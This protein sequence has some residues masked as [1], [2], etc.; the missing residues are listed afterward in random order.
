MLIIILLTIPLIG[1]IIVS[2][3]MLYNDEINHTDYLKKHESLSDASS[4]FKN[5]TSNGVN[6]NIS[7]L[8]NKLTNKYKTLNRNIKVNKRLKT[9]ALYFSVLTLLVSL[10]IFAL[11]DFS[12]N[13]FQFVQSQDQ[14]S[15][16]KL[17]IKKPTRN[18]Y[19]RSITKCF[20][21]RSNRS[22]LF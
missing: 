21:R 4:H 5:S 22:K 18:K 14:I 17:Y 15:V 12:N 20:S 7:V 10:I 2:T 3:T 13:Q 16:N 19:A 1:V 6:N 9:I 11:F 8:K